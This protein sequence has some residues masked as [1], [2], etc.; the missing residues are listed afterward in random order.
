MGNLW[1][2]LTKWLEDASNVVG[3]EAGDLTMKG[4]L[5]LEIFELK[6][7]LRE[8]YVMLGMITFDEFFTK[9]NENW[10]KRKQ[11]MTAVR[12]IRS[13]IRALEK[14]EKEYKKVGQKTKRTKKK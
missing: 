14:K 7:N 3:R 5:K 6:R 8:H 2:D 13:K 11:S 1:H 4:R 12:Q 9:K 10:H